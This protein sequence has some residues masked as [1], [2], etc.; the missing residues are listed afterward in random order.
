M[1]KVL[2]EEQNLTNIANAI[3]GKTG[4]TD[5]ITPPNMASEIEAIPTGGGA[6]LKEKAVNF[7]DYDGTLLYSYTLAE[8]RAMTSLP[9]LPTYDDDRFYASGWTTT[10][11][12]MQ[13]VVG[14]EDVSVKLTPTNTTYKECAVFVVDVRKT[15]DNTV[16]IKMY[17]RSSSY[18]VAYDWGDGTGVK[19]LSSTS[20][21][22]YTHTYAERKKYTIVVLAERISSVMYL[23]DGSN[24]AFTPAVVLETVHNASSYICFSKYCFSGNY[25]LKYV[26][27][28]KNDQYMLSSCYS[29]KV[30]ICVDP[31]SAP[32]SYIFNYTY[33]L[34]RLTVPYP[35]SNFFKGANNLTKFKCTS[36]SNGGGL[37]DVP[38]GLKVL[39]LTTTTV[40]PYSAKI[41]LG[42]LIYVND[43]LVDSYKTTTGWV[44]H[45]NYI[46]PHSAYVDSDYE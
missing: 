2:I 14:F 35:T 22:A 15:T 36:T 23:G 11:T 38:Q 7:W 33:A 17:K 24:P 3:R 44:D 1:A 6:P 41:T 43:D 20:A 25:N 32:S 42:T 39:I 45:A 10:L 31:I 9:Q 28:Y 30:C 8:A 18:N 29:L 19:S 16:N 27:F 21:T 26:V 4:K 34:G 5:L 37:Y 40:M 13:S 46:F 12:K